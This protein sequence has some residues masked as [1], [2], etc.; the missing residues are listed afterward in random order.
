MLKNITF[1]QLSIKY[2]YN[3]EY[4]YQDIEYNQQY[5]KIRIK[6]EIL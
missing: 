2:I 6:L 3:I 4:A 1:K 5:L